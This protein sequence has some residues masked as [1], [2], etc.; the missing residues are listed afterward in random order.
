MNPGK[1]C[2]HCGDDIGVW[3]VF[4]AGLPN[5]IKCPHCKARL[6]YHNTTGLVV[7]LL[8]LSVPLAAGAY[9]AACE[10]VPDDSAGIRVLAFVAIFLGAWSALELPAVWLLRSQRE[11]Q[12]TKPP[13]E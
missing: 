4:S 9:F 3:P 2:P 10:L 11:L 1:D 6:R 12:V 7:T 8:V 5:R 13:P